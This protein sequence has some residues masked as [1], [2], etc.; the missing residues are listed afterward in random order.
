MFISG[1]NTESKSQEY[2]NLICIKSVYLAYA[3]CV[4]I[5]HSNRDSK[6]SE[7]EIKKLGGA[8]GIHS[9]LTMF[10]PCINLLGFRDIVSLS[11]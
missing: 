3:N 9:C 7:P 2:L 11:V 6:G 10:C 1:K 4:K 5:F 8:V